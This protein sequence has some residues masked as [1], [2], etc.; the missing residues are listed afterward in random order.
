[1]FSRVEHW[2]LL[3]YMTLSAFNIF[4]SSLST[5]KKPSDNEDV[6]NTK[7]NKLYIQITYSFMSTLILL[8]AYVYLFYVY[9]P[10]G[11]IFRNHIFVNYSVFLS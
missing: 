9:Y 3:A 5:S 7:K 4:M 10:L 8:V 11:L 1:M 2:M 6:T